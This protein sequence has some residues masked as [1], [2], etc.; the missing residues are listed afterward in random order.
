MKPLNIVID[1]ENRYFAA[2]LRL[3]IA[4]YAQQHNKIAHFLPSGSDER[5]D[6]VL[7]SPARRA[8][9]WAAYS[10]AHVVTIKEKQTV[11]SGR[12]NRV[13]YRTDDQQCLFALLSDTLVNP[14]PV[15]R[16]PAKLL[17]PR[18]RQVIGYLRRG[19]DQS[20]TARVMGVSVKTVHSHKRSVM[21]KL[22]LNRSH[23]FIYWL[24]SPEA[25]YS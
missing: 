11:A 23:D 19:L 10:G 1:D 25:E 14:K 15:C 4:T 22:M 7:T 2:G 3:S 18:E 16:F 17:T 24:L 13:L 21:G 8:R 20:Q 6:I 5:P 9:R 12:A